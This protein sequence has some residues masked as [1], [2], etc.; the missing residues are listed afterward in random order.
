MT[1]ARCILWL[2]VLAWPEERNESTAVQRKWMML[3]MIK[4]ISMCRFYARHV[5]IGRSERD[6][7]SEQINGQI[8]EG[9]EKAVKK[10]KEE[11][12]MLIR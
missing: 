8:N 2:F 1:I 4:N 3:V 9:E 10:R 12:F 5:Y 11:Y 7:E 6:R